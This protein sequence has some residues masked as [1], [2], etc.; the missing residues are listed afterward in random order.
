LEWAQCLP[1]RDLVWGRTKKNLL[2]DAFRGELPARI[3]DRP[4]HGFGAPIRAWL[5]GPLES[6]VR[7]CLPTPLLK[8]QPQVD[9]L[10]AFARNKRGAE[11]RVWTLMMFALWARQ[12]RANW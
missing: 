9:A 3:L 7:A 12:W 6:V 8:R 11:M 4:K 10:Q 2:R 5:K 1:P